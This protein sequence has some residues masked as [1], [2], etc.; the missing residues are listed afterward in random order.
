MS[1]QPEPAPTVPVQQLR[2]IREALEELRKT[3]IEKT[4]LIEIKTKEAEKHATNTNIISRLAFGFTIFGIVLL[5]IF[6]IRV[7]LT[8]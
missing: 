6:A 5:C 7:L 8:L 3:K 2:D 4:A 1:S